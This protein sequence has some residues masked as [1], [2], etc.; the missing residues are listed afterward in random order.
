MYH[1]EKVINGILC[2]RSTPNGEWE[3][4]S[5]EWMTKIILKYRN[6]YKPTEV[7]EDH[8][9]AMYEPD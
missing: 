4:Y 2:Y 6:F 3:E 8:M 7:T 1:E 5:K 9:A